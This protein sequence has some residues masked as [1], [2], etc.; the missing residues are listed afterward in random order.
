MAAN[1]IDEFCEFCPYYYETLNYILD[2]DINN[3]FDDI[4]NEN[5]SIPLLTQSSNNTSATFN[6][7]DK[8]Y[9]QRTLCF[10]WIVDMKKYSKL[11]F[12]N[13]KFYYQFKNKYL[14]QVICY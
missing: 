4:I 3:E 14:Q 6:V 8:Y 9:K 12:K 5:L 13:K 11:K 1:L 10:K 7:I 2:N